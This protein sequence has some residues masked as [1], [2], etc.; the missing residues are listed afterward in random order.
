[1]HDDAVGSLDAAYALNP[2]QVVDRLIEGLELS[3]QAA[4]ERQN[5]ERERELTMRLAHLLAQ[6]EQR[7]RAA[8]LLRDW[9]AR[10]RED[11]EAL[12]LLLELLQTLRSFSPAIDVAE[13]LLGL[14]P[15]AELEEVATQLLGAAR[16]EGDPEAARRGLVAAVARAPKNQNLVELLG[17][18]YEQIDDKR[19]LAALLSEHLSSHG[20]AEKRAEELRR[21]G[22][23]LLG[24]GDIEAALDP[25][26]KALALKPDDV[27]TVLF[28]ADARIA[29]AQFQEAQDVLEHSMTT[30]RQ[31][32][33]PELALLR[34]RMA[35]LS[36][37]AGDQEAR[38]EWLNAALDAD[39]NNGEIASET[40]V[41]AQTMGSFELA[42]KALRAITM[43]KGET[44]MSRAEAFYRQAQIVAHKGEPRRAV[45][46]AK[47]AKAEDANLPGVDQLLAE[48]GEA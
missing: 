45:L 27:P 38:L 18:L 1:M 41:L 31:R 36:S 42:L 39:L 34:L 14:V 43:L 40:A 29:A 19:A 8:D 11:T 20:P 5:K 2:A 7:E 13:S 33:S 26:T 44:A 17:Q 28:I 16:S 37:A 48:L 30:Q 46:W 24:A 35:Q 6:R 32:R 21:I 10:A 15:L 3:R 23:L 12:R 25:L 4:H 47:K 22:Q 9:T